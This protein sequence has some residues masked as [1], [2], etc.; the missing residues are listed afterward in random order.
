[1]YTG[2]SKTPY[3][4]TYWTTYRCNSKCEFCYF[5]RDP[6]LK[7]IP[8]AKF[9]DVKK[10]LDDLKRI[11]VSVVDF[12]GGEPLLN[13]ELPQILSHAKKLGFF[14][15]LSTNGYLYPKRAEELKDLTTC[16]YFS[17]DTTSREEYKK[18]RG[19]D[20]YE[21]LIESIELAKE[22][23]QKI[24]LSCTLTDEIINNMK[25]IANFA[26][27]NKVTAYIHPCF[28][29]FGNKKLS[30]ENIKNIKKY[31][32]H[33]YIRM[34]LSD[35]DLAY[36]GGNDINNTTCLAGKSTVDISPDDCL[37]IPC[38]H[39]FVNKIKIN[40]K[41][42]S[43]Y[44]SQDWERWFK[45]AGKYDYCKHCMIDCYFGLSYWDKIRRGF[46][47]ANITQLKNIVEAMRPQ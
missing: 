18:I 47:K 12:T 9:F 7:G 24:C 13:K 21:Q 17:L 45:D 33:P 26:K 6:K 38:F 37:V 28:S 15:K 25:D 41:L 35:L 4:C 20:G 36:K 5:W 34:S 27:E 39:K 2:L 16:I 14:V 22:L 30:E 3:F 1:M 44:Q 32:W 46:F 11:G 23:N 19:I 10:N 42:Y 8:D 40:G 31:F 43:L 29:Y